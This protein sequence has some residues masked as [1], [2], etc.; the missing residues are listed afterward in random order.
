MSYDCIA[1]FARSSLRCGGR[2][3]RHD[4]LMSVSAK[5]SLEEKLPLLPLDADTLGVEQL[6]DH[7]EQGVVVVWCHQ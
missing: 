5:H 1:Q 6:L 2:H 3:D 7:C 4:E